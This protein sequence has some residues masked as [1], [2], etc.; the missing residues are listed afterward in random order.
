MAELA[1]VLWLKYLNFNPTEPQWINRD[2]FVLSN[3]HGCML[4]YSMLHLSGYD[5]TLDDLKSFRQWESKTPGHPEFHFTPGVE[6]TTGP[7][8]QGI[9]NAVGMALGQKMLAANTGRASS[10]INHRVFCFAGDGCMQEGVTGEASSIAGHLGLDN[11]T[12]IYDDNHI[13]IAGPTE[14]SFSEDVCKRYEAYGWHTQRVDGHD[15]EAIDR[16][17]QIAL[18]IKDRPTLIAAR[19]TIGKGSPHKANDAEVH[20][21]PL[22]KEEMANTRKAL[23]WPEEP[24]HIPARTKEIFSGRVAELT[25]THENWVQ[26]FE[27]WKKANAEL[28]ADLDKR[29]TRAVP[30]DLEARLLKAL[31]EKVLPAATRKL[32]QAVLQAA[33]EAVPSLI[34]GSADLEPSTF[35]L[36]NKSSD[37]RRGEFAG[38]NLRFG[39]REHGMGAIMNG[40]SYYG[41]FI[42]YGSTFLTFS[43]YMRPT[44]RLAA[45]SHLPGLFI[46][47][48][49]SIFLGEDG[50]THQPIEHIQSLRLIKNLWVMRPADG[51]ET[52]ICYGVALRRKDG[53]CAL[54]FSRQNCDPI[55]RRPDFDWKEITCGAYSV[56]ESGEGTPEVVFLATGSEVGLAIQAAKLL[57]QPVRVVSLPC[58]ELFYSQSEEYQSRLIPRFVKKVVIEAGTPHGWRDAFN[59]SEEDTLVIGI[60]RYG[61]SAP[62]KILA[63]KFGFTP[64]AVVERVK[65]KFF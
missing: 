56:Y 30:D 57:S 11:L 49:D 25:K 16:A 4:L 31:P 27:S 37:I 5:V 38:K 64:Q 21:S 54:I 48:H 33:S 2:R 12:I 19:T 1:A 3:G 61:A 59:G 51:V 40:L 22:G 10:P 28:A 7:L 42:P 24:F 52:A 58:L 43:D 53:P 60:D 50:P 9:A 39:I 20:G 14:L 65:E 41:G 45:L 23:N 46:F 47:T 36:I 13:S 26:N 44:V 32:S 18:T 17:L 8:G 35:T 55:E 62:A 6:A 29:L 34:G 15:F 63:E